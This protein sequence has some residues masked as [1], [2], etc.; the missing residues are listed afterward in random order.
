MLLAGEDTSPAST[1]PRGPAI[2]PIDI[3]DD[4]KPDHRHA[5]QQR[6]DEEQEEEQQQEQEQQPQGQ[7]EEEPVPQEEE[8]HAVVSVLGMQELAAWL[9]QAGPQLDSLRPVR[10]A[11]Q[12]SET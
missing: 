8:G 2:P 10:T 7:K 4:A 5:Q 12:H 3:I 6:Q 1:P 11:N 9:R